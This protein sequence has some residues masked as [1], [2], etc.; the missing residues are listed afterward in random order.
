MERGKKKQKSLRAL[1][2]ECFGET[3]L[4]QKWVEVDIWQLILVNTD[5]Q[6]VST[7]AQTSNAFNQ[8]VEEKFRTNN[9]KLAKRYLREGQTRM[10]RRCLENCVEHGDAE[11][12]VHMGCAHLYGGWGMKPHDID[13][14]KHFKMAADAGNSRGM[15]YYA[16][17]C[18]YTVVG[19]VEESNIYYQRA[20]ASGDLFA[21]AYYYY[22]KAPSAENLMKAFEYFTKMAIEGDEYAQYFLGDAYYYGDGT[23]KNKY[24]A[25]EWYTKSAEQGFYG[26]QYMLY[27]LSIIGDAERIAKWKKMAEKQQYNE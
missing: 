27:M 8:L 12:M 15:V 24:K 23:L 22:K 3:N 26:S 14:Y 16:R 17:V 18:E 20:V 9:L 19:G 25:I 4:P 7:L 13:M 11:A 10:A 6:S 5:L 1:L 2:R 21:R